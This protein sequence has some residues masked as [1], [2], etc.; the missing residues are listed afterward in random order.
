MEK[1]GDTINSKLYLEDIIIWEPKHYNTLVHLGVLE[2]KEGFYDLASEY[3]KRARNIR[4][5]DVKVSYNL[6]NIFIKQGKFED[7]A[8]LLEEALHNE[9]NNIKILQKLMV[10]YG[11]IDDYEKLENI[12]K[13]VLTLDKTNA[14]AIAFL[15]RA[16]KE[17]NKFSQLEK[18]LVKIETKLDKLTNKTNKKDTVMKIKSK[19]KDKIEEVKNLIFFNNKEEENESEEDK[20]LPIMNVMKIEIAEDPNIHKYK[21]I[22]QRDPNNNEALFF[23]GN[24]AFKVITNL[25]ENNDFETAYNMFSKL[26]EIFPN[27]NEEEVL[28]RL[29]ILSYL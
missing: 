25:I 2:A 3:L 15:S 7:A 5:S 19:L 18:L 11:K 21:D 26:Q 13:K 20:E 14:K 6:A 24:D 12:C 23:L 22:I 1:H 10:C 28:E 27:F 4:S 16:L 29:G 17:N 9:E 8:P